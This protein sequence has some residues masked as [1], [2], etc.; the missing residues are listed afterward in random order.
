MRENTPCGL[1]VVLMSATLDAAKLLDYFAVP[2]ETVV[3]ARPLDLPWGAV[4]EVAPGASVNMRFRT[5]DLWRINLHV[6]ALLLRH[7]L[8]SDGGANDVALVFLP[9]KETIRSAQQ[10]LERDARVAAQLQI[11]Q[12]T[13]VEGTPAATRGLLKVRNQS[14]FGVLLGALS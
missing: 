13:V 2:G 1:R 8:E 3:D 12:Q 14:Q 7:L 10:E 5:F 6:I 11:E 4:T 9:G